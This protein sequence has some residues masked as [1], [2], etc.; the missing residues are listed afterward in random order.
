MNSEEEILTYCD[1][2]IQLL[3]EELDVLKKDSVYSA[4]SPSEIKSGWITTKIGILKPLYQHRI[5]FECFHIVILDSFL[6]L[7]KNI[8]QFSNNN[9][10]LLDF[11]LRTIYE[12]SFKYIDTHFSPFLNSELEHRIRLLRVLIDYLI[13]GK[14]NQRWKQYTNDLYREEVNR[15]DERE[16][17]MIEDCLRN[18]NFEKIKRINGYTNL[19]YNKFLEN[20]KP[21]PFLDENKLKIVYSLLS[22]LIHGDP[23]I[24]KGVIEDNKNKKGRFFAVFLMSTINAI[25]RVGRF[26]NNPQISLKIE[27]FNSNFL[28]IWE[29]SKRY[30][31]KPQ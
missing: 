18:F 7:L 5:L 11:S 29:I 25:N 21:L 8:L 15:L 20:I 1:K 16:K 13:L 12:F 19:L 4:V 14:D 26:I 30:Y 27:Y 10:F 24:I 28:K 2:I 3:K 31:Y 6:T 9:T 22:H 23:F 17:K